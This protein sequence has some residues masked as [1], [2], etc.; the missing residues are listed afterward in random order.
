MLSIKRLL[1]AL[2]YLAASAPMSLAQQ[3]LLPKL[4]LGPFQQTIVIRNS[5]S[6]TDGYARVFTTMDFYDPTGQPPVVLQNGERPMQAFKVFI[7][8]VD[9]AHWYMQEIIPL[10]KNPFY[11][12]ASLATDLQP[13]IL[14]RLPKLV[15]LVRNQSGELMPV[16]FKSAVSE[17][18]S[19]YH[20][21]KIM[22]IALDDYQAER[23]LVVVSVAL[24]TRLTIR[25]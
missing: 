14:N 15:M 5:L 7:P 2:I 24:M 25:R 20:G 16:S 3:H 22:S 10:G 13:Y 21:V 1:S 8:P 9:G 11:F 6:L 19:D 12:V 4:S 17:A 18:F 23:R